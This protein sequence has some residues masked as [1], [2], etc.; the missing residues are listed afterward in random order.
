MNR[1]R[2]P[3]VGLLAALL[4]AAAPGPA[5]SPGGLLDRM[6]SLNPNLRAFTATLHAHVT[7]KSFPFLSADLVGTYYYKQP[8]KYKVAFTSGV[9]LIAQQFDKLYAHIEPPSRWRDLY[10]V[11]VVSDDGATTT[12]RLVPRKRG[13]VEH[14]D[15]TADDR[16]ATVTSLRWNYYNGGNAEMTNHYSHQGGNVV[17]AS[18]TG[19]VAEPGYVA[20]ISSTIDDYK[21]NAPL[22]DDI[23]AGD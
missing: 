18:Q 15:A 19:H 16:T 2:T 11:T 20:D 21:L 3:I 17:V 4:C 7:M 6:A 23:F 1:F 13:N 22:S 14:I 9:P 10:A 8:D 5:A 12:F